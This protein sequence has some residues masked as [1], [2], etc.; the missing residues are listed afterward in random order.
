MLA[1]IIHDN[2]SS[3]AMVVLDLRQDVLPQHSYKVNTRH[4]S[5]K[6]DNPASAF[7]GN[8][9]EAVNFWMVSRQL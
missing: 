7:L 8:C 6:E 4:H 9:S 3:M 2:P 5:S 1:I